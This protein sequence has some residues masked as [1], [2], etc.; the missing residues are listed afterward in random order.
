MYFKRLEIQG[1]KSFADHVTIDFHRGITCIVGPNGSGKSNVSDALRWVLGEQSP[2]TL[3][4]GKMDEVIFNGTSSRHAK[5]MAEVTL[6]IDNSDGALKT[7]YT[8]VSI[9]RRMFR[10]GTTEYLINNNQCRLRDIKELIMD[11]GIGVDGYSIIG[12]G[13]ISEI[14]SEKP[15]SR[16]A[17]FEES[18]GIVAYK[19]KKNDAERKLDDTAQNLNRLNDIIGEI[20]GRIGN[21]KSESEKAKRYLELSE[22]YK[23][24]EVNIILKQISDDE[25]KHAAFSDEIRSVEEDI[26]KTK[27]EI[28]KYASEIAEIDSEKSGLEE[29][30]RQCNEK[31]VSITGELATA[32]K[33]GQYGRQRLEQIDSEEHRT[34]SELETFTRKLSVLQSEIDNLKKESE[35]VSETREN[36]EKTLKDREEELSRLEEES[37][38]LSDIVNGGND[39]LFA[40]HSKAAEKKSEARSVESYLTSMEN[41]KKEIAEENASLKEKSADAEKKLK[42]AE[43]DL[44]D[45]EKSSRDND[46]AIK[47][48]TAEINELKAEQAEVRKRSQEAVNKLNK[49]N[50]RRNALQEMESSYEGYNY[51]VRFIMNSGINGIEGV[52]AEL[53]DVPFGMET[54]IETA[55]GAGKQNIVTSDDASARNAVMELKRKRAGRLTFLPVTSVKGRAVQV[56]QALSSDKGFK[57]LASDIVKYDSRYDGIMKYLLG[58]TAIVDN[59]DTAIALSK[60]AVPGM[61]LVTLDGEVV[62]ASGAI[63]GGA[64]KSSGTGLLSRR[65]EIAKLGNS[66]A[67]AEKEYS[68][69]QDELNS[70]TRRGEELMA[71]LD[72]CS[73]TRQNCAFRIKALKDDL[74]RG[75]R[76]AEELRKKAENNSRELEALEEQYQKSSDT[77]TG[78]KD[79]SRSAEEEIEKINKEIEE[80]S[81]NYEKRKAALDE[82]RENVTEAKISLSNAENKI[83]SLGSIIDRVTTEKEDLETRSGDAEKRLKDLTEERESL[84]VTA[85]GSSEKTK[86]LRTRRDAL[87]KELNDIAEKK[88]KLQERELGVKEADERASGHMDSLKDQQYQI[89]VRSVKSDEK[90]SSLKDKLWTEFEI[91]YAEA[92]DMKDENF[93]MSTSQKK[94][95]EVRKEIA[96]LGQVNVSSI[97]E[98]EKESKRLE[99]LTVQRTD[100]VEAKEEL[101]KI[102]RETDNTIIRRFRENFANINDVFQKVFRQ[103]FGGGHAELYMDD[104]DDPLN[105][106]V[107]IKAQPPGKKLQNINLMSG[108]EKTMTA[109]ALIFA[110]LTVKPTP[111]CILDEVEAALDDENI[112]R[113][114]DYLSNFHDTQFA[115]ITHHKTTMEKADVLYGITMPERGVSKLL[116]LKL[117]DYDEEEYTS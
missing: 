31:L 6:V 114:S 64:Y 19:T 32:D 41:R 81:E 20:E 90:L 56:P 55:L 39:R 49:L 92:L 94:C 38:G 101:E 87:D 43:A 30:E 88:E 96:E 28:E 105:T 73:E 2:K 65:N 16:R 80:A 25:K 113:F 36:A 85:E 97:E 112:I 98:Y 91:S 7:D 23:T 108:G 62:S 84:K 89:N 35:G 78:L 13:K 29:K 75:R 95:R 26:E 63:T 59:I 46:E 40:L 110:V 76:D 86:D 44:S 83:R 10:D 67:E 68:S 79:E 107:E 34:K 109:I 48:T 45:A 17:I 4:G 5:G 102:I 1:F 12:Q 93:V 18:A 111:F 100:V 51:P 11:T 116:S 37:K 106:G 50:A 58:R 115:V 54:A 9:T 52:T 60:K 22:V 21:L 27:A 66:A 104:P 24:L 42:D 3:R 14:V 99:F 74:E 71:A 8:E 103:L 15:E 117:E 77:M 53:I 47:K 69:I 70:I 57:G 33:E 82:A 72:K 61:R